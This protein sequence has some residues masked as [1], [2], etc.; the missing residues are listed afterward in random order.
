M[1]DF[2]LPLSFMSALPPSVEFELS[3]WARGLAIF[4]ALREGEGCGTLEGLVAP[5]YSG[6][7]AT[8]GVRDGSRPQLRESAPQRLWSGKLVSSGRIRFSVTRGSRTP[9]SF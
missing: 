1:I 6:F 3:D 7:R 2:A 8:I 4:E 9:P 5:R